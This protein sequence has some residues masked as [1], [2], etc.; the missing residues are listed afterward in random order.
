M[1]FNES[2][3][4]KEEL[5]RSPEIFARLITE[6]FCGDKWVGIL[7]EVDQE[8]LSNILFKMNLNEIDYR[9]LNEIILLLNQDTISNGYFKF[10]FEKEKINLDDLLKGIK[11]IRGLCLLGFGNFR[12]PYKSFKNNNEHEML[13][14]FEKYCRSKD[15]I[16]TL[17]KNRP[18][19]MLEINK[20]KKEDTLFLGYITG[21]RVKIEGSE[22]NKEITLAK[23]GNSKFTLDELI[24]FSEYISRLED[25]IIQCQKMG[26]KN[27]DIYLTWDYID[28]YVATSMRNKWE[29]EEVYDFIELVFNDRKLLEL[30]LRYFDPTQS[31][32]GNPRDKGLIE[33]LMLKRSDCTIYLAQESD[34]MGKDSELAATLAQGKPVIVYVP[35]PD[36]EEYAKKIKNYPLPYIKN[37]FLNLNANNRFDDPEVIKM[38]AE[39]GEKP[40]DYI[41]DFLDELDKYR[42]EQPY[43]LWVEKDQ[44]FKDNYANF[45]VVC[46]ILAHVECYHYDKRADTLRSTHPLSMQVDL[47]TGVANGVLVVRNAEE[48]AELLFR[49]LTNQM[50]FNIVVEELEENALGLKESYTLLKENI[51][52][53]PYRIVTH[54]ERL[55]N[56]FWNNFW[57]KPQT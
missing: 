46:R 2:L 10:I 17:Y 15:K 48:C 49:I 53:S 36:P 38:L 22:L 12:Y 11:K 1:K 42:Q 5:L 30:K 27:T 57:R 56:S 19:K 39:Y 4:S 21:T 45:E 55:T 7:N 34:T 28:I 50:E 26:L 41:Q 40:E 31:F 14:I 51:S 6:K 43:T 25:N 16:I 8:F 33:G 47:N 32:C 37:R 35:D 18:E 3:S 52:N 23:Q 20:I 29:F 13:K 9:Q 44:K 54:Q 24:I